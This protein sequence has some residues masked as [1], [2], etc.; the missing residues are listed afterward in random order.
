MRVLA[1]PL[2]LLVLLLFASPGTSKPR[3]RKP[4]K[5][6]YTLF[7]MLRFAGNARR[8]VI[9]LRESRPELDVIFFTLQ[10]LGE[11]GLLEHLDEFVATSARAGHDLQKYRVRDVLLQAKGFLTSTGLGRVSIADVMSLARQVASDAGVLDL[12]LGEV[13][14]RA[15]GLFEGRTLA[16]TATGVVAF[17]REKLSKPTAVSRRIAA[18]LEKSAPHI[19]P[20]TNVAPFLALVTGIVGGG[21]TKLTV[22]DVLQF[23]SEV[24]EWFEL[25]PKA[26]Q[27][28][29]VLTQAIELVVQ[30]DV[31]YTPLDE[32]LQ[33]AA[34]W[35]I[36]AAE[37]TE[38]PTD[39]GDTEQ[40]AW[41]G[42]EDSGEL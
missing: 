42:E 16:E 8:G 28:H 26:T 1:L 34:G 4:R 11:E 40:S 36:M 13:F 2:L 21:S 18:E 19:L 3:G 10:E 9:E 14:E 25:D 12:P 38:P 20:G 35:L 27:A 30:Y 39:E 37:Q 7:D 31:R 24:P 29:T 6:T 17:L 33:T 15:V 32:A 22:E 5:P 23:L 41:G